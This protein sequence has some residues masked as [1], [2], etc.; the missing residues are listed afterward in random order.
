MILLAAHHRLT[1]I[2][3]QQSF[4][5]QLDTRANLDRISSASAESRRRHRQLVVSLAVSVVVR[6]V[7]LVRE[8]LPSL[9]NN[10]AESNRV[11]ASARS[12]LLCAVHNSP[13]ADIRRQS[14]S[15]ECLVVR[16]RRMRHQQSLV[17]CHSF[18]VTRCNCECHLRPIDHVE[19][20]FAILDR[21]SIR[22]VNLIDRLPVGFFFVVIHSVITTL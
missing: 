21:R 14:L 20:A 1:E 4:R 16:R 3:C 2:E 7:G 17:R 5:E 9:Q 15:A 10:L 22:F 12:C 11:Y 13:R 8:I 18:A 19:A 6:E